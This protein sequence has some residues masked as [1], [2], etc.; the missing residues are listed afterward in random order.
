VLDEPAN[1]LDPLAHHAFCAVIRSIAEAGR[2]VLLSSHVLNEA[3]DVCDT[4]ILLRDGRVLRIAAVEEMQRQASRE[5]AL[6]YASPPL[7]LPAA[8]TAAQVDGCLVRGRI[9]ARR[10]DVLREL[11]AEPDLVDLTVV[12]ASLE[13]LF[14]SMYAG[15]ES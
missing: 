2:T 8:L 12:P 15:G 10:P 4:V 1:R 9:P 3:E 11:L 13:D 5:V 14:L 7:W 6:T